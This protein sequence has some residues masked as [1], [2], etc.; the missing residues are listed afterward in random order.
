[1]DV[2][3]AYR[4]DAVR[5]APLSSFMVPNYEESTE[6]IHEYQIHEYESLRVNIAIEAICKVNKDFQMSRMKFPAVKSVS[7]KFSGGCRI[8]GDLGGL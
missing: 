5:I 1:M 6:Q 4:K 8:W 2:R 3:D 7:L